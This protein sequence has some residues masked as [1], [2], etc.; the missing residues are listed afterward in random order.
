[1]KSL[2][3]KVILSSLLIL[4]A[5]VGMITFGLSL[6]Y[7]SYIAETSEE[8][9]TRLAKVIS[10]DLN[11]KV[12]DYWESSEDFHAKLQTIEN[13]SDIRIWL[14]LS[15][16]QIIG[17]DVNLDSKSLIKQLHDNE[18]HSYF[19]FDKPNFRKS[20][21]DM[22]DDKEYYTLI[23]PMYLSNG[24]K[25]ILFLNKSI[26]NIDRK[27]SEV[28][29]FSF[30]TV[31]IVAIYSAI[32]ISIF[33]KKIIDEIAKINKAVNEMAKG[34][35][36]VKLDKERQDEFGELSRNLS[37]MGQSLDQIEQSR[38]NFVSNVSHDLRSPMTSISAYINGILDG[39]IP[40]DRWTHYL[41]VVSDETKR[42]IKLINNVLDLSR[43]QSGK[44]ELKIEK[45]DLNS[46]ILSMVDSYEQKIHDKNIRIDLNFVEGY[47]VF[48]DE[49]LIS[50][51]VSNLID[52]AIKF[53]A[54][55]SKI[56]IQ[57]N[58]KKP[59]INFSIT[60]SGSYIEPDKLK[61]I[62]GRFNKL[63]DSRNLD[64]NSSGIGLAIVKEIMASH[65]EPIYVYSDENEGTC[66]KFSLQA[67]K[68]K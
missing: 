50:R 39:T 35:L 9:L 52:N 62:W 30:I 57:T 12:G 23:Y 67:S 13:Y 26:P 1:M 16:H 55:G 53:S 24:E 54:Y 40:E 17:S 34:N 32:I 4:V 38:R 19:E 25:F 2:F 15:E 65:D 36:D 66:F 37:E 22:Y 33:N 56:T 3:S 44:Y 6:I 51:V 42:M 5:G 31:I 11:F 43:I 21:I 58:F 18:E 60:N 46:I 27:N 47:N 29:K 59:K 48:C 63:D 14:M 68:A 8:E 20:K 7:K 64:K 10:E 45:V 41:G 61:F 49:I 28:V